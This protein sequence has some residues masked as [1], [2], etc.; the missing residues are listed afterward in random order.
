MTAYLA[1][2]GAIAHKGI[3]NGKKAATTNVH[4]GK[5]IGKKHLLPKRHQ[6]NKKSLKCDETNLKKPTIQRF[7][8]LAGA[9]RV[10]NCLY[11][12]F[13]L[14][15]SNNAKVLLLVA[16][17]YCSN[18]KTTRIQLA[19]MIHALQHLNLNVF[20]QSGNLAK[21]TTLKSKKA[22][23]KKIVSDGSDVEEEEVELNNDD[24]EDSDAPVDDAD[25][26]DDAAISDDNNDGDADGDADN[27]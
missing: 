25:D 5:G 18:R 7:C 24:T 26:D 4:G 8:R 27:P 3:S 21:K 15:I 12:E 11:E 14:H 16:T 17:Q 20:G 2:K 9:A 19:D 1:K 10:K 6:F 23:F 22:L 13:R